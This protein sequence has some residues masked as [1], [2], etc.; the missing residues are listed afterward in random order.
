[1]PALVTGKQA[2]A[3]ARANTI[4]QGLK[5]LHGTLTRLM[6]AAAEAWAERD[7]EALGYGS[8]QA[9][10]DGEFTTKLRLTADQRR[11]M[12]NYL[13]GDAAMSERAIAVLLGVSQPTVHRDAITAADSDESPVRGVDGKTYPARK[14]KVIKP[15]G[16]PVDEKEEKEVLTASIAS[17]LKS[18]RANISSLP[19]EVARATTEIMLSGLEGDLAG[20]ILIERG[21]WPD[22]SKTYSRLAERN[23]HLIACKVTIDDNGAVR[24]ELFA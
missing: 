14:P 5:D 16:E 2:A 11:Q 23:G 8:W 4:R 10:V 1:M 3:N 19:P 22:P 20:M 6:E 24:L 18:F 12:V 9:Y 17:H 21:K 13:H 15:D 7:W